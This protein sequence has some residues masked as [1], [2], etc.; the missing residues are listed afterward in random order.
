MF[1]K[2]IS[3][4]LNYHVDIGESTRA[5]VLA[6]VEKLGYRPDAVARSVTLRRTHILGVIIPDLMHSF[7]VEIVAGLE[8]MVSERGYGLV[9]CASGENAQKERTRARDASRRSS[10]TTNEE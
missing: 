3:K 9:L 1:V 5:R 10:R 8:A 6:G 7:S 4:V 2:T